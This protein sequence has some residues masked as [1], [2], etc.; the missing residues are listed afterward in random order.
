MQEL[1]VGLYPELERGV[2]T[3]HVLYDDS[4]GSYRLRY[5]ATPTRQPEVERLYPKEIG[6]K[7]FNDLVGYL[8]W[9]SLVPQLSGP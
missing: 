3:L 7:K 9:S 5:Y 6:L 2:E 1:I 8:N 4:S